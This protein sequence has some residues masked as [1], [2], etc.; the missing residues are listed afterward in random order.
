MC[1]GLRHGLGAVR[2]LKKKPK[3]DA[4]EHAAEAAEE[5]DEQLV[6]RVTMGDYPG[7]ARF[8]HGS[9]AARILGV[10]STAD[11]GNRDAIRPKHKPKM[12]PY[13][14]PVKAKPGAHSPKRDGFLRGPAVSPVAAK[15]IS[16][17]TQA[18]AEA[19][20]HRAKGAVRLARNTAEDAHPVLKR[21]CYQAK[22]APQGQWRV[23]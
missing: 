18:H 9:P 4:H 1:Q 7:A 20:L 16:E 5:S 17:V 3:K 14:P 19:Q 23:H 10:V 22:V 11:L 8:A 6:A 15:P 2:F 12:N 13:A 21:A